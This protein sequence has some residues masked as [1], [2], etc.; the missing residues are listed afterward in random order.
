MKKQVKHTIII[1]VAALLS[2]QCGE[3]DKVATEGVPADT[4][5]VEED[6]SVRADLGA[7]S[8]V[9]SSVLIEE[10]KSADFYG[11]RGAGDQHFGTSW[12]TNKNGGVGESIEIEYPSGIS[13]NNVV[14]MG[15][16]AK[17][18]GLFKNNNRVKDYEIVVTSGENDTKTTLTGTLKQTCW[19][20]AEA[21]QTCADIESFSNF[22]PFRHYQVTNK[23][24]CEAIF[25]KY[26]RIGYL[27]DPELGYYWTGDQVV[28]LPGVLSNI[29]SVKLTVKSVYKGAKY[30]DLCVA[31]LAIFHQENS[32]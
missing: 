9:A 20:K 6:T 26:C 8:V 28:A 21:L 32:Y 18:K 12:C 3:K 27:P 19:D 30:N 22:M 10:K 24:E 16:Y 31:N 1:A 7:I 29:S 13:A 2:L 11:P 5:V 23:K 25:P 14:I 17:T 15:G 4:A